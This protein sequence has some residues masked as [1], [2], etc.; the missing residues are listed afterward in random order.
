MAGF[1]ALVAGGMLAVGMLA[2]LLLK[3][4]SAEGFFFVFVFGGDLDVRL[5]ME[6]ILL[7]S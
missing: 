4:P 3:V 7:T 1:A 2:G 6:E 5:L